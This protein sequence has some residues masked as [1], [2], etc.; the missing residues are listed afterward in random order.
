MLVLRDLSVHVSNILINHNQKCSIWTSCIQNLHHRNLGTWIFCIRTFHIQ[1]NVLHLILWRLPASLN[2]YDSLSH[3]NFVGNDDYEWMKKRFEN[4]E[5]NLWMKLK[6]KHWLKKL[7]SQNF[8][9]FQSRSVNLANKRF[10]NLN[11]T[12]DVTVLRIA[13][14]GLLCDVI[15]GCLYI[16]KAVIR[17][18]HDRRYSK[19]I[20]NF[21]LI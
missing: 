7:K 2:M 20:Q 19:S 9:K 5:F 21:H 6:T 8:F 10:I 4:F 14:E 18:K 12:N 15:N 13:I 1:T 16:L 17:E 11:F 3:V